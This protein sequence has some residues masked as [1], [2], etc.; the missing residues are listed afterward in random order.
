MQDKLQAND[1]TVVA[2]D[3]INLQSFVKVMTILQDEIPIPKHIV[4]IKTFSNDVIIA[5]RKEH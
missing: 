4:V 3:L 1:H 5:R 2:P